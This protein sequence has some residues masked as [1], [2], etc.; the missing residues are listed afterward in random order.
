MAEHEVSSPPSSDTAGSGPLDASGAVLAAVH[1]SPVDAS[2]V[3]WAADEAVRLGVPLRLVSVVDPGFQLMPYEALVSATPSLSGQLEE[4]ARVLLDDAT[5]RARARHP[6][7]DVAVA[8]TWG[9][10]AAAVLDLA[11]AAR[12][13]VVGA[14]AK[15]RLERALLGSVALPVVAH[16]SCPTV[17]VPAGTRIGPLRRL[18]VGVDGSEASGRAVALAL[19]TAE[20]AG[21]AVSCVV[22]WHV[23][24]QDGI[25]VTERGSDR[26]AAV[27][28][29]HAARA[30]R[31]VDPVSAHWPDVE[32][33]VV[34]HHGP[35]S[36]VL[37]DAAAQL[38][39]DAVVVGS[40]GLGGFRGLLLGSV[41]R[42]VIEHAGRVVIVAR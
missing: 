15:S 6:G 24:V 38:E 4:G 30:H 37:I 31:V 23:E 17:V 12:R 19:E 32:V 2:V 14:S 25:V 9:S 16:A 34:V 22:G 1:G 39:A 10:P 5:G 8:V 26:W 13:L 20:A 7:L 33:E 41:S 21:A 27:E 29:R 36:K 40:R 18:V 35:P 42:R 28:E 3:D 11:R